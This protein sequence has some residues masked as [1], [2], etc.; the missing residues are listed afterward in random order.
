ME[1]NEKNIQAE[2]KKGEYFNYGQRY[3]ATF[4]YNSDEQKKKIYEV[5]EDALVPSYGINSHRSREGKAY[6]MPYF[7]DE[8]G[9]MRTENTGII[10][11]TS[12]PEDLLPEFIRRFV[13]VDKMA[14]KI[15]DKEMRG[16]FDYD[17]FEEYKGRLLENLSIEELET[18]LQK[19]NDDNQVKREELKKRKLIAQ[20]RV[21][22]EEGKELDAQLDTENVRTEDEREE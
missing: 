6:I 1:N 17:K 2:L 16:Q 22:Q 14:V 18:L 11:G 9:N 4:K 5:F 7:A 21:A 15:G 19:T 13:E 20:I 10:G 12:I 8:E 3:F